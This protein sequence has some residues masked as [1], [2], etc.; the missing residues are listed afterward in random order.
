MPAPRYDPVGTGNH[1]PNPAAHGERDGNAW[2]SPR[3]R[4]DGEIRATFLPGPI[5]DSQSEFLAINHQGSRSGTPFGIRS[6]VERLGRTA[7]D[8][9]ARTAAPATRPDKAHGRRPP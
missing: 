7:A 8:R 9:A 1:S 5:P 3:E 4:R 2:K 6:V